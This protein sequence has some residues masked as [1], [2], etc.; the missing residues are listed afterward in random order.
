M[1]SL[2]EVHSG[3]IDSKVLMIF[4]TVEGKIFHN[5]YKSN[6][7]FDAHPM[8]HFLKMLRVVPIYLSVCENNGSC[9]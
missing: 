2:T 1:G 8:G 7:K 6:E 9:T 4:S 3:K 5:N